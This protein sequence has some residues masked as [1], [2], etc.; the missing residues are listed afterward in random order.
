MAGEF[1]P[2]ALRA[3]AIAESRN[4]SLHALAAE[5]GYADAPPR[6]RRLVVL[7]SLSHAE[8]VRLTGY[9]KSEISRFFARRHPPTLSKL[10]RIASAY[11]AWMD[12]VLSAMGW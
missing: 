2:T 4:V 6:V 10:A 3:R 8:L 7:D 11:G 5:L 12:D 9:H 1:E